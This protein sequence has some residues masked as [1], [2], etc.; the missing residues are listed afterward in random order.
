MP[1]EAPLD[2][3]EFGD[4]DEHVST[5]ERYCPGC[6]ISWYATWDADNLQDKEECP[7]CGSRDTVS[8][9]NLFDSL[10]APADNDGF[11]EDEEDWYCLDCSAYWSVLVNYRADDDA[12]CPRC[13]SKR[14]GPMDINEFDESIDK[15]KDVPSAQDKA[16]KDDTVQTNPLGQPET[17]MKRPGI[18]RKRVLNELEPEDLAISRIAEELSDI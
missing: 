4:E 11:G 16:T 5:N 13:R 18:K 17:I 8:V 7:Q 1:L 6:G 9:D 2:N 12:E 15:S 14:I 10:E 3:D